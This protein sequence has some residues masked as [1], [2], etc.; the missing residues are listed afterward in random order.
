MAAQPSAFRI[1]LSCLF[2]AALAMPSANTSLFDGVPLSR[3]PEFVAL[4]LML[5]VLADAGLRARWLALFPPRALRLIPAGLVIVIAAK[6]ALLLSGT[7]E[8][9]AGCYR[10]TLADPLA[11]GV[12]ADSGGCE[13]S[14][15]NPLARFGATRLDRTIDFGPIPG[16]GARS[17][18]SLVEPALLFGA[19]RGGISATTW[20]L[21]F[22]NSL[23]FNLY[24]VPEDGV[25]ERLPIA[26]AWQGEIDLRDAAV[27]RIDYLGE[28][29]A[30][31]GDR[32]EPLPASYQDSARVN[33]RL[34]RGRHTL[35]V[36]YVFDDGKRLGKGV[37]PLGPYGRMRVARV[38]PDDARRVVAL[39]A[40]PPP[41]A[42]RAVA[43]VADLPLALIVGSVAVSYLR[44][45]WVRVFASLVAW[46][47]V[48]VVMAPSAVTNLPAATFTIAFI[49]LLI[50]CAW[51]AEWR[52]PAAAFAIVLVLQA[53]RSA[54][55]FPGLFAVLY[56]RPGSDW[57][58]YE[59]FARDILATGSLRAAED[60]FHYQPGFRY[61]LFGLRFLIVGDNDV[62]C[63]IVALTALTW[64]LFFA[65]FRFTGTRPFTFR[66]GQVTAVAGAALLLGIVCSPFVVN[67]VRV[68]VS[69]WPTWVLAPPMAALLF[70]PR[71]AR[72]VRPR[73]EP[74]A[75]PNAGEDDRWA[76]TGEE[77]RWT[78]M[79]RLWGAVLAG[80]S[81]FVRPQQALGAAW[82]IGLSI[83]R[84]PARTAGSGSVAVAIAAPAIVILLLVAHNYAYGGRVVLLP[85]SAALPENVSL[86]W[87][88]VTTRSIGQVGPV[89][90]EQLARLA[91][92]S[93]Q[94]PRDHEARAVVWAL[95]A[96]WVWTL[97]L[98]LV[99]VGRRRQPSRRV[100]LWRWAIA[101]WPAA[102]LLPFVSLNVANFYPRH[103]I[104]AWLAMG[105]AAMAVA[106]EEDEEDQSASQAVPTRTAVAEQAESSQRVAFGP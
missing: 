31:I 20:N 100:D 53:L 83:A 63:G 59:S 39:E 98:P 51:R 3:W 94:V 54:H 64:G 17:S 65:F 33:L 91:Y 82:A 29:R 41:V 23:R 57:L 10:S 43:I 75:G 88:D 15:E 50:A 35:D 1:A 60:V 106:G 56:R 25:T 38:D 48:V 97:V 84:R 90:V 61:L 24:D 96:L 30:R 103:L 92:L 32:V 74:G 76:R 80:L 16:P 68:G 69:E 45:R 89:L 78:R 47:A 77:D 22:V 26:A 101:L 73:A 105:L 27:I 81:L 72:R 5:P 66:A 2:V 34:P 49:V 42:W 21:S 7:H 14:Y 6:S 95:L 44:R 13:L 8:G 9:F 18:A 79:D 52:S 104:I 85:L 19:L 37:P 71:V 70:A 62:L 28:G 46:M 12:A 11:A 86:S 87:H 4:A 67:C 102:H 93:G 40:A 99:R 55:D 36:R 58:T